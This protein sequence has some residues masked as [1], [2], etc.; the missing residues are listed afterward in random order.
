MEQALK[1]R[2]SIEHPLLRASDLDEN[3]T[4]WDHHASA[5]SDE[6]LVRWW[7]CIGTASAFVAIVVAVVMCAI[8]MKAKTR[9][10][11]FNLYLVGLMVPD[12][13]YS[14]VC[15]I[16]CFMNVA[17]GRFYS[18]MTCLLQ[19]FFLTLGIGGNYWVTL[20]IMREL[21]HMLRAS[22]R[23]RR[24]NVASRKTAIKQCGMAL[25]WSAFVATW[26]L[27]PRS[28]N[29]PLQTLSKNGYGCATLDYDLASCLFYWLVFFPAMSGVP[30]GY[31]I[32]VCFTIWREKLMPRQGQRKLITIY[33]LRIVV[34]LFV[35]WLPSFFGIL[36]Y[37][38]IPGVGNLFFAMWIHLQG[39][40]SALLML[41][42]PDVLQAVKDLLLCHSDPCLSH[43]T[44]NLPASADAST[45]IE[46]ASTKTNRG[47]NCNL[48]TLPSTVSAD[49]VK[50][51]SQRL[52]FG[53][54]DMPLYLEH[55]YEEHGDSEEE[56]GGSA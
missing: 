28:W 39:A 45:N 49:G 17:V 38:K 25:L 1:E 35:W 43:A 29:I 41:G 31:T 32:Y 21:L 5:P 24:Y 26:G 3:S 56:K 9:R 36:I 10:L 20:L 23:C 33:L 46:A 4:R 11:S 53:W 16:F 13:I 18:Q 19:S 54:D 27:L 55:D 42:K 22:K 50:D 2:T 44:N 12:F 6:A 7:I 51:T 52:T 15:G 47:T 40:A 30:I 37:P 8:L 48:A 34:C 14:F